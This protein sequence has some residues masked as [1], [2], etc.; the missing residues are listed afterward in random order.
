MRQPIGRVKAVYERE[1]A[2]LKTGARVKDYF[3]LLT[4]R[5]TREALLHD[6][7]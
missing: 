3:A 5:K 7:S 2:E 1:F 4:T 6:Q